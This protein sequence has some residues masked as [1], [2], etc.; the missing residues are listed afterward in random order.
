M[1]SNTIIGGVLILA[2][3]GDVAAAFV[4]SNRIQD[5]QRRTMVLVGLLSSS[6][7]MLALG[8]AFLAGVI[9]A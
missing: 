6:A 3:L 9:G 4:L 5:K 1:E 8:G 2:A 7:L